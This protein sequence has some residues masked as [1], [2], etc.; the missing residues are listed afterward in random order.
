MALRCTKKIIG[1][2]YGFTCIIDSVPHLKTA[3]GAGFVFGVTFKDQLKA[4]THTHTLVKT[5]LSSSFRVAMTDLPGLDLPPQVFELLQVQLSS[6]VSL[7]HFDGKKPK[8]EK[9]EMFF[10][11]FCF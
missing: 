8:R 3:D 5:D 9:P 2:I 1:W 10:F 6:P 11:F 4:H 7:K